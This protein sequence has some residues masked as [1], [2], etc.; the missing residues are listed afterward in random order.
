MSLKSYG[1]IWPSYLKRG[2]IKK[3]EDIMDRAKINEKKIK[4]NKN[5]SNFHKNDSE[6]KK[7]EAYDLL[8]KY[9]TLFFLTREL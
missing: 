6:K 3:M 4:K 2:L 1:L 5:V 9:I 8:G 7:H